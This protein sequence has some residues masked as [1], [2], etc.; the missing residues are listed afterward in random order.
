MN[1]VSKSTL[2]LAAHRLTEMFSYCDYFPAWEIAM[3]DLRDYRFYADD[4]VHPGNQM[5]RYIWEKF[6]D[7][8][9]DGETIEISREIRKLFNAR[10]HR[11]FD[12]GSVRHG[13][14]LKKQ[15]GEL[16]KLGGKYPFIDLSELENYFSAGL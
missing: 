15:L 5:V 9:F 8:W 1:S 14:F 13:E 11:P 10:N 3:D 7:A 4:L 12:P 2:I 6:A 16:R